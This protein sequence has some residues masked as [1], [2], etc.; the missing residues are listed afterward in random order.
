METGRWVKS[1]KPTAAANAL[2]CFCDPR[3]EEAET[4]EF[5]KIG[6]TANLVESV[7]NTLSK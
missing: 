3:I 6:W 2:A 1:P 4:G 5:S 7:R